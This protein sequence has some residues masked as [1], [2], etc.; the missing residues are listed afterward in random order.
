MS[1]ALV[2]ELELTGLNEVTGGMDTASKSIRGS[3]KA[4]KEVF[5][6]AQKLTQALKQLTDA[7]RNGNVMQVFDAQ[8]RAAKAQQAYKNAQK[9]LNPPAPP[10]LAQKLMSA[11]MSSRVGFGAG[12]V[13][14][15]PLVNRI[16]P[17]L[18]T[19]VVAATTVIG[20]LA[21]AAKAAA[22]GLTSFRDAMLT[23]GGTRAET[24]QLGTLGG[25]IGLSDQQ[26]ARMAHSFSDSISQGGTAAGFAGR[27]GIYDI[28]IFGDTDKAKNLLKWAAALRQMS[29]AEATRA[30]RAT[31][32]EDLL[33]FRDLSDSTFRQLYKD[34]IER[35]QEFS[36]ERVREAAQFN[37]QMGRLQIAFSDL[38]VSLSPLIRLFA[39]LTEFVTFVVRSI[40]S[41]FD[42]TDIIDTLN[43]DPGGK[44]RKAREAAQEKR[45]SAL[46]KNTAALKEAAAA[47]KAGIYGGGERARATMPG[48]LSGFNAHQYIG[49]AMAFGALSL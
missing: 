49:P 17:L 40:E 16:L 48:K 11:V 37:A 20:G 2:V 1:E 36:P 27:A 10:S 7:Q 6:P 15:M 47:M 14:L 28:G 45:E 4:L 8:Y 29:D 33:K 21:A 41:L 22:D 18:G 31:G 25:A 3:G 32:T 23:S 35:A 43:G 26:M 42:F 5:G 44:K 19:Q 30:A 46:D 13:Q 9:F 38:M 24:A 39:Y 12:G 34:A